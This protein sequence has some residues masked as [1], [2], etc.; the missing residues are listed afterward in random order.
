L[1]AWCIKDVQRAREE[2]LLDDQLANLMREQVLQLR[3]QIGQLYDAADLPI[4]FFY[5][6]FICL[7]T[8]L[9]LPLFAVSA[10]LKAGT[11]DEMSWAADVVAGLVVVFQAIFVLGLRLLGQQ[12][13][14]PFGEDL[15]DLNVIQF[16]DFT[17]MM[18]NRILESHL[19]RGDAS[20]ETERCMKQRRM[21]LGEA[22]HGDRFGMGVEV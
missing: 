9:Y 16:V 10:G 3:A 5:V 20:L 6:H 13:N 12:M 17:C 21:S 14:D 7:L 19:D 2:N 11:G 18:S 8:V 15:L 4:P 22:W 1:I